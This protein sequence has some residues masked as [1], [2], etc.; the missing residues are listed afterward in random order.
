MFQCAVNPV[1]C[2]CILPNLPYMIECFTLT[3][4]AVGK[5]AQSQAMVTMLVFWCHRIS[6]EG[7]VYVHPTPIQWNWTSVELG[8]S[9]STVCITTTWNM[10]GVYVV[11]AHGSGMRM[12]C[13][14]GSI[15]A[16][17]SMQRHSIWDFYEVGVPLENCVCVYMCARTRV[18]V[19]GGVW[20]EDSMDE[21]AAD[22]EA[23]T[24]E[25]LPEA[26]KGSLCSRAPSRSC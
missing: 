7:L 23:T 21:P 22:R 16:T 11:Q 10:G 3:E 17:L 5:W 19:G 20:G 14:S 6:R 26:D 2:T 18:H 12:G 1:N 4:D 15:Q 9:F 8:S 25:P 13:V 24:P